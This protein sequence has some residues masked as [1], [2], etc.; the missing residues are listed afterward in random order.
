[1]ALICTGLEF[2]TQNTQTFKLSEKLLKKYF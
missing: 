1:M 2:G